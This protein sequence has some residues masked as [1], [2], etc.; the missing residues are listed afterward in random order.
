MFAPS[1]PARVLANGCPRTIDYRSPAF[2]GLRR[3]RLITQTFFCSGSRVGCG[4]RPPPNSQRSTKNP[5]R[6][7]AAF[8]LEKQRERIRAPR[9]AVASRE[10]GFTLL[11]LLIVVGIIGLLLVLIAPAFTYIKGG[12]DV[13]SAAYTIKGVLDTA[14]TYAKANNTYTWVGFYEEDVS[15]PSTNP[16][17]PGVGRL[18]MSVVASKNGTKIYDTTSTSIDPTRLIPVGKLVKIE[19]VHLPLF[20]LGTGNGNTFDTRP[21]PTP[22][23]ANDSRFGEL[24]GSPTAPTTNSQYPFQYPVGSPAPTAQYTF[25]KT[26]QFGPRGENQINSGL[27]VGNVTYDVKRIVEIGLIQTHGNAVPTPTP[28]AGNYVGNVVAVQINGFAGDV[29]IYRR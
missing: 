2:N 18:V 1:S 14:R 9:P 5:Q 15:Q 10:G 11:E 6:S 3:G 27:G 29:R 12:T 8:T 16:P 25:R 23:P 26:L 28:S 24:N 13:T 19:N 7:C 17:T 4:C 22:G 20:S 21:S